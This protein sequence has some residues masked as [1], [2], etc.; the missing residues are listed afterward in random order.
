[1]AVRVALVAMA[2]MVLHQH[3][4]Q[5]VNLPLSEAE[6]DPFDDGFLICAQLVKTGGADQSGLQV[7]DVFVEYG[8][9]SK[10]RFPG[11]KSI[12]N[13]M[14]RYYAPTLSGCG[15]LC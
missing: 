14:R 7:G 9:C 5:K 10:K 1:M 2:L 11:L 8:H 4:S 13:L 12:A 3:Q 6:R 15:P